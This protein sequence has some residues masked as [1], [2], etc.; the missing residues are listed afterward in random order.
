MPTRKKTSRKLPVAEA[1]PN[2]DSSDLEFAQWAETHSL[3]KLMGTS[4]PVSEELPAQSHPP[5]GKASPAAPERSLVAL[6]LSRED[7]AAARRI[8]HE[9]DIPYTV[10][11]RMWI[12]EGL[13]REQEQA[14]G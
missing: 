7:I 10:L 12:R 5:A 11:L 1:W 3:E 4:E 6:R 8:A 9:K 2:A 13:K 14:T